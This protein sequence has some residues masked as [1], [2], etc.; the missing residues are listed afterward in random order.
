MKIT[1][2]IPVYNVEDYIRATLNSLM[3]QTL[4][5]FEVII[6]NDDSPDNSQ[7]IINEFC[8]R[9]E[10]FKCF[11]QLNEGVAAARNHGLEQ[12]K[13]EYVLFVDGDDILPPKALENLY[14]Q[15]IE[16]KADMVVGMMQENGMYGHGIFAR[17][18]ILAEQTIVDRY[19]PAF[20]WTFSVCNKLMK[21]ETIR[22][23]NLRFLPIKHA[24]DGLF[25][26]NFLFNCQRIAGCES[27]V[28]RYRKRPFWKEKSATQAA[29]KENLA[30]LLIALEQIE[31]VIKEHIKTLNPD[32]AENYMQFFYERA[33]DISLL[34]EYYR[35]LW[36]NDDDAF[37]LLKNKYEYYKTLL[38][39]ETWENLLENNRDL[40][41]EDGLRNK[42]ELCKDPLVTIALSDKI[43]ED[44]FA[45]V[46]ESLFNQQMPAF[47]VH[48]HYKHAKSIPAEYKTRENIFIHTDDEDTATFKNRVLN[49]AHSRLITFIDE[50]IYIN[51]NTYKFA[52]DA[53]MQDEDLGFVTNQLRTVVDEDGRI[54]GSRAH[55]INFMGRYLKKNARSVYNSADWMSGNKIFSVEK[56]KEHIRFTNNPMAD[57]KK[58]YRKLSHTGIMRSYVFTSFDNKMILHYT[59]NLFVRCTYLP[60]YFTLR[61]LTS[62]EAVRKRLISKKKQIGKRFISLCKRIIPLKKKVF[63]ISIRS[64]QLIENNKA[65]YEAYKG[66]K[67]KFTHRMPHSV[68]QK[69]KIYWNLIS[70]KVIV[71]DDYLSYFRTFELKPEQKAIQLWHACG[72]FK[73][74]ALDYIAAD[75]TREKKTHRQYDAVIV[76][77]PSVREVYAHAFGID[78]SKVLALGTP[79]TDV[80]LKDDWIK[81]E[82]KNF[83]ERHPQWKDKKLL[84]YT[85]TFREEGTK[86]IEFDPQIN[87]AKFSDSLGEDIV[88][89]VKNHPM[90]KNDLLQ[91]EHYYNIVNLPDGATE[92]LLLVCD[93]LITDYSSTV[94]EAALLNKPL[95]LYC[96][97]FTTYERDFYIQVPDDLYGDLVISQDE[98]I[99]NIRK[100]LKDPNM[101]LIELQRFKEKYLS[102]CDGFSA[103][104][105]A[106]LIADKVNS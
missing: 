32:E 84:L 17:T 5:D 70:S 36:K 57:I 103:E 97:D 90:M 68:L 21:L 65:V 92:Q 62:K 87:W 27:V 9:D 2:I 75:I 1:V 79:R 73:K 86:R 23:L 53:F 48:I 71:T 16:N 49:A 88:F 50:G 77:S 106:K 28:Y 35:Q 72:A 40:R 8:E 44:E 80:L 18:R 63:F 76:S 104:R 7:V 47:V 83:Y 54:K 66:K 89:I 102:S 85:P 95:I 101:Y 94:F 38:K 52:I 11:M 99:E 26:F 59:R 56:L 51:N 25:M 64:N 22:R 12:A 61:V 33:I 67:V 31:K 45:R 34:R 3:R 91:G 19:D 29:T 81:K 74:F 14:R 20:L 100:T 42:Q 15:A 24:E 98:L 58:S 93:V 78:I 46:I 4:T 39:A 13:G 30:D 60:V 96:P 41:L 10:R 82:K 69:L 43:P 105:V 6:I 37:V 55:K